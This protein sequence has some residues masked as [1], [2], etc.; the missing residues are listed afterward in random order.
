MLMFVY[1]NIQLTLGIL[2]SKICI[3]VFFTRYKELK[4]NF[5]SKTKAK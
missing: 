3:N 2:L 5:V 1:T 4:K